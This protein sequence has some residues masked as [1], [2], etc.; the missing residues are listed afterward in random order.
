[1]I[2]SQT[3]IK[4]GD[5]CGIRFAKC[6]SAYKIKTKFIGFIILISVKSI[7]LQSKIKK[8]SIYKGIVIRVKQKKQRKNGNSIFFNENAVV[9]LNK[10][11]DIL[12]TRIFGPIGSELRKKNLLKIL[13]L[14]STIL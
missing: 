8:G 5:N 10:K 6:L 1:M 13:S 3:K 2:Q 11:K 7:K 9:I 12:S 4:I 14:G